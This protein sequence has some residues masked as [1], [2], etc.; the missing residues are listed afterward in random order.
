MIVFLGHLGLFIPSMNRF[1]RLAHIAV[2]IFFVLSGFVIRMITRDHPGSM[3]DFLIDRGSR[4]YSVTV[5]ALFLTAICEGIAK[6]INPTM[7]STL[8]AGPFLWPRVMFAFVT[9]LTFTAQSWG[10]ET[11]PL[12]NSPFWSL[13]FE[14]VYYLLFALLF[15]GAQRRSTRFFLVAVIL[16]SGP[17]IIL[18]FPT[19]LLGCLLYDTYIRLEST[20]YAFSLTT[21][22]LLVVLFLG[23]CLRH[24]ISSILQIT[25]Y[26]HR[27]RW[28]QSLFSPAMRRR[29][30]D[31]TGNVPWLS[32]FSPSFYFAAVVIFVVLLWSLIAIQRFLPDIPE[33][34]SAGLRWVAEGTF[35]LYLFHLPILLMLACIFNGAPKYAYLWAAGVVVFCILVSHLCNRL[36]VAMRT[37]AH[38]TLQARTHSGP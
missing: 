14:C 8:A 32:R 28:L 17:S 11:N 33:S 38:H 4:I 19:W 16:V 24:W 1:V 20:P 10:Y 36:K 25:D 22:A 30:A 26:T 5:P 6:T 15:F 2:C 29:L 3:T 12:S 21:A 27:T 9:N 34:I 37:Y 31:N 7:Y 35:A 18:L 23:F 13:S